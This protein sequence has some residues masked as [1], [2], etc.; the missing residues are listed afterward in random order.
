MRKFLVR[1]GGK[2]LLV[3]FSQNEAYICA[4]VNACA[5]ERGHPSSMGL[6]FSSAK[7]I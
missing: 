5:L 7:K 1:G 6:L 3:S 2:P 4:Y